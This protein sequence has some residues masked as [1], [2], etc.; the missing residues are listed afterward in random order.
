MRWVRL[1]S[2]LSLLLPLLLAPQHKQSD[3][4]GVGVLTHSLTPTPNHI[5]HPLPLPLPLYHQQKLTTP[6]SMTT[7]TPPP[8]STPTGTPTHPEGSQ[9]LQVQNT[10]RN[11]GMVAAFWAGLLVS[12]PIAPAPEEGL[13]S[14]WLQSQLRLWEKL[15]QERDYW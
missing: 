6:A 7:P 12:G 3:G 2:P 11:G 5:K 9:S 1:A 14:R 4:V 15:G 8:T 13:R 10:P